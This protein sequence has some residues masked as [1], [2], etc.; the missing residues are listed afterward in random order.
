M[1][2]FH[3]VKPIRI[4]LRYSLNTFVPNFSRIVLWLSILKLSIQDLCYFFVRYELVMIQR[5]SSSYQVRSVE[6]TENKKILI[7][8]N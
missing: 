8:K 5:K 4:Y 2:T 1:D 6:N 3:A 7:I